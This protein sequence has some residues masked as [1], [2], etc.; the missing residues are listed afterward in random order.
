MD[1]LYTVLSSLLYL[2]LTVIMIIKTY[3]AYAD[4]V[5]GYNLFDTACLIIAWGIVFLIGKI[6]QWVIKNILT[7]L[8]AWK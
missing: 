8:S 7:S 4:E 3:V 5:I 2:T 1:R 6:A